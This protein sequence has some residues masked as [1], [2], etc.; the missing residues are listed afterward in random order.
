MAKQQLTWQF[1]GIPLVRVERRGNKFYVQMREDETSEHWKDVAGGEFPTLDEALDA[2][3]I[4]C[5]F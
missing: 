5:Y 1:P 2:A 4:L 3:P